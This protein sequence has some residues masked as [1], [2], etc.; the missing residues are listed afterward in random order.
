MKGFYNKRTPRP[1][2]TATWSID[3]LLD[4][5]KEQPGDGELDLKDITL[6]TVSLL[7]VSH[8]SRAAD[9]NLM[10]YENH[11]IEENSLEFLLQSTPKQQRKGIL[12]PMIVHKVSV[13][14]IDPVRC[15]LEYMSRTQEFRFRE[16]GI[17]R[18][19]LFLSYVGLHKPV[20]TSTI[21]KWI[22]MAM[23]K[24]GIDTSTFRAHSTRSAGVSTAFH[25]RNVSMKAIM[26]RGNW[27]NSSVLKKYYLRRL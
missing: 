5:W 22:K 8:L 11:K 25:L 27:K 20:T 15:T 16:D 13:E 14:K 21:S 4:F 1:R 6:K 12:H 17:I 3:T 24:A 7:A 19:K 9:L 23:D 26:R 18:D 10:L 2:Y